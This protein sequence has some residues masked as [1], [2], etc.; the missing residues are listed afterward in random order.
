MKRKRKNKRVSGVRRRRSSM[1]GV[2]VTNILSVVGGAVVAGYLNKLIPAT[3]N[4]KLVAG[5]KVAL[6]VAL[7]MLSKSGQTKNILSGVGAGMIAV[8]SVDL[9]KSF[10][11]LSGDFDIPV[12]NGDVLAGLDVVNGD[13]LAGDDIPVINGDS[14]FMSGDEFGADEFG[15]DEFGADEFGADEFGADDDLM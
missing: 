8:G 10:G 9:L 3:V 14:E 5:G 1:N 12:I 6:G 15:A 11:A 4:D 7:P 2:D 13:V